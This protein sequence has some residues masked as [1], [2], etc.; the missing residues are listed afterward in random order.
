MYSN[1]TG[2][3]LSGGTSS[4]MGENKALLPLGKKKVIEHIADLMCSIFSNVILITNTPDE[5][6]FL[7]LPLYEDIF[8]VGGPL[9]GIHSGLENSNTEDN[10]ILS[11]DMPLMKADIIKSIIEFKTKK[12]VTVCKSEGFIQ[13]LAGRYSKSI[14]QTAGKLLQQEGENVKL[15]NEKHRAKVYSLLNEVGFETIEAEEIL[16]YHPKIFFNMNNKEDYQK[17][18]SLF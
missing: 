10:Y 16:G 5:Y 4:R 2:I 14:S 8:K 18:L 3:M 7:N 12:P 9:A 1:I 13:H 6:E 11:C 15:K 17:I